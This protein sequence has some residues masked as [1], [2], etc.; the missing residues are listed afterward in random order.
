MQYTPKLPP[1]S[2]RP[3]LSPRA[4]RTKAPSFADFVKSLPAR[5]RFSMPT[6]TFTAHTP[7]MKE[8]RPESAFE[9]SNST[10]DLHPGF[11]MP[12][13]TP[14]PYNPTQHA[15]YPAAPAPS[16]SE[17]RPLRTT[18]WRPYP[19]QQP[20]DQEFEFTYNWS[21][22]LPEDAPNTTP[23]PPY[24]TRPNGTIPFNP[25]LSKDLF[26]P[27]PS[28][29]SPAPLLPLT[30]PPRR[31]QATLSKRETRRLWIKWCVT[32][33][34]VGL[35]IVCMVTLGRYMEALGKWER[36]GV[37]VGVVGGLS[38]GLGGMWCLV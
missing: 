13:Y 21:K 20:K 3:E 30:R 7:E 27:T 1:V 14:T 15:S 4:P 29:P 31:P 23:S 19:A 5:E 34:S 2:E 25:T 17:T 33:V 18:R 36:V 28:P 32:V 8:I 22:P 24:K 10:S 11:P 6:S 38:V 37:A 16:K 26:L 9:D 35:A 12:A